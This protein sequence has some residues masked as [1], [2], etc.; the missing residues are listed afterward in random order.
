MDFEGWK[1]K[2]TYD[3]EDIEKHWQAVWEAEK[4]LNVEEGSNKSKVY[5]LDMFPGPSGPLHM[6]HV[7]NYGIGDVIA[8]YRIR[9]GDNLFR[10]IGWDAF[11]LPAEIAAINHGVHP[12]EWTDKHIAIQSRQFRSLGIHNDWSAEINTSDPE[13]YRWNQWLFLK[14]YE[15]GLA[16]RAVR[17]VNWCPHCRTTLA[18]EEVIA[19]ACERCDVQIIEKPL[20]QWFLKITAFAEALLSGL[21]DLDDW[22]DPIKTIQRNWIGRSEGAEVCFEIPS[23]ETRLTVFTT[24]P[25]TLFGITFIALSSDHP[26]AKQVGCH[27]AEDETGMDTGICA[28][29]PIKK[30]QI[31]IF[32]AN[33]VLMDY[34]TGAIMGV[35]AHDER[36]FGFAKA[37]GLPIKPVIESDGSLPNSNKGHLIHSDRFNGEHSD[38]ASKSIAQWLN[39]HQCGGPK[40]TFK[41]R[42]WCISRQRYWGTPIPILHCDSCGTVPVPEPDLPV[43]L[44]SMTDFVPDGQPPLSRAADFV[45]TTSPL[46]G[47]PAQRECDTM[48]GIVCSSWYFLRYLSPHNHD[49]IFDTRAVKNW[50]PVANYIGGKEHSVGHLMYARFICHFLNQLGMIDFTEPFTHL[51]NQGVVGKE[52]SK[53]SKSRGNVVSIEDMITQYGADT[54]RLFVLFATPPDRDMEWSVDGV[55]GIHRFLNRVWRTI[56]D[57]KQQPEVQAIDEKLIRTT[58]QTIQA[59]TEDLDRWRHN[60]A[61]SRLMELTNAIHQT[62]S[63]GLSTTREACETLVSLIAPFAPHLAEELWHQLGHTSSIHRSPWPTHNAGLATEQTLKVTIQVNGKLRDTI[64][65]ARSMAKSDVIDKAQNSQRVAMSLAQYGIQR[66]IYVPNRLVNFVTE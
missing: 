25:D 33:Y 24:R 43:C 13:Y 54:A 10:P 17:S 30:D 28:V 60:T 1:A 32:I 41:L 65:V 40:V 8:R 5:I 63:D 50:L 53:M 20:L 49:L 12:R 18:N 42:D 21:D 16:Y 61:I 46:C 38:E 51:F 36:D 47:K 15:H 62:Q 64:R 35:P 56:R 22:P 37:H 52:G 34:G 48:T 7:K 66:T 31:P 27:L 19:G 55:A 6:G 39:G 2:D 57:V 26:I 45:Q 59:V 3:F 14:L 58:H 11:G 4:T 23:I 9:R 29:H 44:P